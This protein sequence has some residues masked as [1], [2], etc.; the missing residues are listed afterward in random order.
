MKN[1]GIF[2]NPM[3][4]TYSPFRVGA[5]HLF[6]GRKI[7]VIVGPEIKAG[8]F[9]KPWAEVGEKLGLDQAI[10]VVSSLGPRI[11]KEHEQFGDKNM[12]RY[13]FQVI[14]RTG[15]DKMQVR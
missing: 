5:N 15:V 1:G 8:C 7:N 3:I 2:E 12:R 6:R 10:L 9:R 11:G 14:L 4:G 13:C